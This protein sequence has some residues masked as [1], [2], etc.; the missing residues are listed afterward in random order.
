MS[1][2]LGACLAVAASVFSLTIAHAQTASDL[3]P[4]P[5]AGPDV[6][7]D[8]SSDTGTTSAYRD[9]KASQPGFR[10]AKPLPLTPFRDMQNKQPDYTQKPLIHPEP[11]LTAAPEPAIPPAPLSKSNDINRLTFRAGAGW[12]VYLNDS[13]KS[14]FYSRVFNG[15]PKSAVDDIATS[16]ALERM[17]RDFEAY[18]QRTYPGASGYPNCGFKQWDADYVQADQEKANEFNYILQNYTVTQTEWLPALEAV[19]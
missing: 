3:A 12:C 15:I 14:A 4:V 19:P 13:T 10:D 5:G 18:L 17:G 6:Q 2:K 16:K 11:H 8:D 9:Q 7:P 1:R